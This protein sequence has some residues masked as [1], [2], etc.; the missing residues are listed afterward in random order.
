MRTHTNTRTHACGV[1]PNEPVPAQGSFPSNG[2]F[3]CHSL[4]GG[5]APGRG[6]A[7]PGSLDGI[8]QHR[9]IIELIRLLRSP[10]TQLMPRRSPSLKRVLLH[11]CPYNVFV[12]AAAT[13]CCDNPLIMGSTLHRWACTEDEPGLPVVLSRTAPRNAASVKLLF[14]RPFFFFSFFNLLLM[15]FAH[16]LAFLQKQ[17]VKEAPGV[18]EPLSQARTCSQL[19]RLRRSSSVHGSCINE[20]SV[21]V[22]LRFYFFFFFFLFLTLV[23]TETHSAW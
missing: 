16:F 2:S 19:Q 5:Q 8:R 7:P 1:P 6:E 14:M 22:N 18:Q 23:A 11:H 9:N 13:T 10:L 4:I 15:G 12:S 3:S 17:G 20:K 21:I